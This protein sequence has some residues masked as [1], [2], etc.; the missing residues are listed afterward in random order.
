MDWTTTLVFL[1]LSISMGPIA[2]LGTMSV[3]RGIF[4]TL[5]FLGF[6]MTT[7]FIELGVFEIFSF[8][9]G[10]IIVMG[11]TYV[12]IRMHHPVTLIKIKKDFAHSKSSHGC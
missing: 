4:V 6:A 9:L 7:L 5:M 1:G 2:G 11:S 12:Y 8:F 10:Q 3:I